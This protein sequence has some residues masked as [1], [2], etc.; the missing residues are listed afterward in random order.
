MIPVQEAYRNDDVPT[1]PVEFDGIAMFLV[2]SLDKF[3]EAFID[4]YYIEVIEPDEREMIDKDG[5]GNGIV[6]NIH[7]K[8][9]DITLQG[10]SV[11]GDKGKSLEYRELFEEYQKRKTF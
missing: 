11:V 10:K 5:P 6:A 2:P 9:V 7:G 1:S 3:T 8:M 4:P